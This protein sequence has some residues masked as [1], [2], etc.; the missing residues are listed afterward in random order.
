MQ[1]QTHIIIAIGGYLHSPKVE[2]IVITD[3]DEEFLDEDW[4][5]F[6]EYVD[7]VLEESIA[8]YNQRFATAICLTEAQF[9]AIK[10]EVTV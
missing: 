10:E 6:D 3:Q 2:K 7:Y 8:E 5:S 4:D 1:T 9:Q